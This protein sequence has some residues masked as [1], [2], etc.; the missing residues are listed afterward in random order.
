M[1]EQSAAYLREQAAR[2]RRLAA[3]TYDQQTHESLN[4]SAEEF[5]DAAEFEDSATKRDGGGGEGPDL[6]PLSD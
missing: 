2:C 6:P 1:T 3:S 4:R 5:D